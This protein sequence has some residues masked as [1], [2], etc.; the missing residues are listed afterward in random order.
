M[1]RP[2]LGQFPD[3]S[4]DFRP[5]RGCAGGL[6]ALMKGRTTLGGAHRLETVQRA[7]LIHV[8]EH[9][10]L[11]ESGTHGE[12]VANGRLY[13]RLVAASSREQL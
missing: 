2:V 1:N 13:A 9:G 8:L 6:D 7:D 11:V 4:S 12:L 5:G 10:R 3:T